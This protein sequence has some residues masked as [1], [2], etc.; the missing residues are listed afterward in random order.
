VASSAQSGG[1]LTKLA[2]AN[3]STSGDSIPIWV[4]AEAGIFQK[5]GLDVDQQLI[6]GAAASMATLISGKVQVGNLGGSAADRG[7]NKA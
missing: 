2:L 5:N 6:N 1:G 7:L 3:S 4:A